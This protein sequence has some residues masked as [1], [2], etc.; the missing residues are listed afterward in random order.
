MKSS[1]F[2]D[3]IKGEKM[4]NFCFKRNQTTTLKAVGIIDSDSLT[5]DVDGEEKDIPTLLSAFNGAVVEFNIK[6]K[7][8]EDLPEPK[9]K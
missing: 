7:D 9:N 8:Q 6:M 5:I 2:F 1:K 4:S 3:G